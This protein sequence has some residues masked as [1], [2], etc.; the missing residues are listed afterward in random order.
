MC[1]P[2]KAGGG[3][4]PKGQGMQGAVLPQKSQERVKKIKP[5]RSAPAAPLQ[6]KPAAHSSSP[7]HFCTALGGALARNGPTPNW[8]VAFWAFWRGGDPQALWRWVCGLRGGCVRI[9]CPKLVPRRGVLRRL[10]AW[11]AFVGLVGLFVLKIKNKNKKVSMV[12]VEKGG[13]NVEESGIEIEC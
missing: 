2:E 8:A 12:D 5:H 9:L 4:S 3:Q 1:L 11:L 6:P 7:F 10:L 13:K